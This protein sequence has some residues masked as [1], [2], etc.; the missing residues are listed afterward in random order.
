MSLFVC[1][2]AYGGGEEVGGGCKGK[3]KERTGVEVERKER[4]SK[5]FE[6]LC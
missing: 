5:K 6:V 3:G 1:S 2:R 4:N